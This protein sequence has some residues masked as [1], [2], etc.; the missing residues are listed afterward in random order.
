MCVRVCVYINIYVC[1]HTYIY[2][3]HHIFFWRRKWQPTPEFLE[4]R[5]TE[6]P[7][8]LESMGSQEAEMT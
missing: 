7:G 5:W 8:G 3:T 4:I 1:T 6:E 2:Y